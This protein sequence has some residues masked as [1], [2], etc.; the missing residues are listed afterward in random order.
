MARARHTLLLNTIEYVEERFGP[1][2]HRRVL[3]ALPGRRLSGEPRDAA[4]DPLEDVVEYMEAAQRLLAPEDAAFFRKL[5]YYAGCR[6]RST[7]AIAV[8][9]ESL[10]TAMRMAPVIWAS[11]VDVGRLEVRSYGATGATLR[12][13]DVPPR[14]SIC[15]R[16]A[17]SIEGLLSGA[18][19]GI[20]VVETACASQGGPHCELRLEWGGDAT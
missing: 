1:G 2:T 19:P 18:A 20:R 4:W 14:A 5:G 7:R 16:V 17:G 12:L 8:M 13:Y 6:D 15:Q 3:E 11:F 9:V 10:D